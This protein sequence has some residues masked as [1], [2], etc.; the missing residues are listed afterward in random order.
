MK[1]G[2]IF[3]SAFAIFMMLALVTV[4]V[5]MAL[6]STSIQ[7]HAVTYRNDGSSS[8]T[9]RNKHGN[10]QIVYPNETIETYY[11]VDL[12]QAQYTDLT[13]VSDTPYAKFALATDAVTATTEGVD[14]AID[15]DADFL[16]IT[17]VTGTIDV[18]AQSDANTPPIFT[19][20]SSDVDNTNLPLHGM[21]DNIVIKGTGTCQITQYKTKF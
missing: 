12:T 21:F 3:Q 16:M 6:L 17:L 8:V 13:K 9:I 5:C 15:L 4:A 1:L 20:V 19:G 18:Y 2:A 10:I 7:A 11:Y 14:V